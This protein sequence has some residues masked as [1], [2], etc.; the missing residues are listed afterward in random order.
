MF[1]KWSLALQSTDITKLIG[2]PVSDEAIN[3]WLTVEGHQ[4]PVLE[5]GDYRTYIE[6]PEQ[7]YSVIFSDESMF[8]GN[9]QQPIGAGELFLS[10]VFF[11]SDGL[12]GYE[13]FIDGLPKSIKFEDNYESL[14]NKLGIP[15]WKRHGED[16]V[17]ISERWAYGKLKIHVTYNS[18]GTIEIIS[19]SE[20]DKT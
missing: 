20:P 2:K 19:I 1:F 3:N 4:L 11:Y 14:N 8:L 7:G 18:S 5:E 12:D 9:E 17:L 15:E 6:S 13:Q 16:E 10:G